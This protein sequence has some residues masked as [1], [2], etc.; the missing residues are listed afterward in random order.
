MD[1]YS[2]ITILTCLASVAMIVVI[3]CNDKLKRD[4]KCGFII[5][6]VLLIIAAVS[7]WAV[8]FMNG[9]LTEYKFLHASIKGLEFIV[10]PIVPLLWLTTMNGFKRLKQIII[11]CVANM[12]LEITS[13]FTGFIF[14]INKNGIYLHGDFYWVYVVVYLTSMFSLFVG[15]IWFSSKYQ[16]RNTAGLIAIGIFV[17]GGI[18]IHFAFSDVRTDRLVAM[19]SFSMLYSY[20]NA[21]YGQVDALTRL[22]NR[23]SY[24]T[25]LAG[26]KRSAIIL[27]FDVDAF[28]EV[29]DSYGHDIGD[30]CLKRIA[31]ILIGTYRN[32]GLCFRF[33]GDEFCA[34]LNKPVENVEKLNAAFLRNVAEER[35][36]VSYVLPHVS[37]GYGVYTPGVNTPDS[38][39]KDADNMMYANKRANK[40][41]V[42]TISEDKND[43]I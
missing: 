21:L 33:G 27:M 16:N 3:S 19:I 36:E 17:F 38:A 15:C 37:F 2:A 23:E 26:L 18:S 40:K 35:K 39:V 1:Y 43:K 29:N 10:A 20:C 8:L 22:L 4:K 6:F 31:A 34:I 24:E 25:H 7:E 12:L 42:C 5:A 28:K 32:Y 13:V 11:F 41:Q 30:D 9:L 14:V